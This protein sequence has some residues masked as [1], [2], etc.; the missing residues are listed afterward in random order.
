MRD[1]FRWWER[2][3]VQFGVNWQLFPSSRMTWREWLFSPEFGVTMPG[4][5]ITSRT[6]LP[7]S[8]SWNVDTRSIQDLSG[9][10][11]PAKFAS[12]VFWLHGA[13]RVIGLDI[14]AGI[15]WRLN[16]SIQPL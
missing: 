1:K 13:V 4:E 11:G 14:G 7:E 5:E 2:G 9:G 15:F 16:S 8:T 6:K 12:R 3:Q 10:K